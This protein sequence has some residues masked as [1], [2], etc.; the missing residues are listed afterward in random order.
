MTLPGSTESSIVVEGT[1]SGFTQ[2][3]LAGSY[4]FVADEPE[5]L[6]GTDQGALGLGT[7]YPQPDALG[8]HFDH[9]LRG[10]LTGRRVC[11]FF[12]FDLE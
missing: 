4:R 2:K 11:F 10:H 1:V 5:A 8:S 9:R 7:L 3:V 12:L 6:G